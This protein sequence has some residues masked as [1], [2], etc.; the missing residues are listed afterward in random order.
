LERELQNKLKTVDDDDDDDDDDD[1]WI[2]RGGNGRWSE[3][4]S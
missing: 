2:E 3:E 1:F 4:R